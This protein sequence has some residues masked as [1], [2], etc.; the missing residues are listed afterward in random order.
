MG[1]Q[2][3]DTTTRC[4]TA[5]DL[6]GAMGRGEGRARTPPPKFSH[7]RAKFPHHIRCPMASEWLHFLRTG[8]VGRGVGRARARALQKLLSKGRG[9]CVCATFAHWVSG[10][11]GG[12]RARARARTAE[13]AVKRQRILCL[14]EHKNIFL[15]PRRGLLHALPLR[16][17]L[18]PRQPG[19]PRRRLL[20]RN[21]GQGVGGVRG[22][23]AAN[24][25]RRGVAGAQGL[26]NAPGR[27][28][29]EEV[30][31]AGLSSS[32]PRLSSPPSKA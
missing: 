21:Q 4:Q 26:A 6:Q 17:P 8:L 31:S 18:L 11:G 13:I 5:S 32:S 23:V 30:A 3:A 29:P 7:L 1:C 9:F 27:V 20:H 14:C 22:R 25:R 19:L 10:E 2:Q 28:E 16:G 12:A 24:K 15:H